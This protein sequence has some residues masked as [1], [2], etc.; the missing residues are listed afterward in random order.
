MLEPSNFCCPPAKPVVYLKEIMLGGC[1]TDRS[2]RQAVAKNPEDVIGPATAYTTIKA[3]PADQALVCFLRPSGFVGMA[4]PWFFIES[5]KILCT[6]PNGTY[7]QILV[8]PGAH[9]FSFKAGPGAQEFFMS[10]DLQGGKIYC[11]LGGISGRM[12]LQT[13]EEANALMPKLTFRKQ[14]GDI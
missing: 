2:D 5:E 13:P 14:A 1:A 6:L 12:A 8:T 3:P 7:Y 4:V 10:L 11:L 9:R